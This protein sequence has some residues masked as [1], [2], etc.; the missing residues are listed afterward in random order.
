MRLWEKQE[1][2]TCHRIEERQESFSWPHDTRVPE[3]E[4]RPLTEL[5]L[6]SWEIDSREDITVSSLRKKE[7]SSHEIRKRRVTDRQD[8]PNTA[9]TTTKNHSR[10]LLLQEF[11]LFHSVLLVE[12]Y[13]SREWYVRGIRMCDQIHVFVLGQD[14][15]SFLILHLSLW[16]FLDTFQSVTSFPS[17]FNC[18]NKSQ[19]VDGQ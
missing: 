16:V 8:I 9:T 14:P 7:E 6:P 10:R 18:I 17:C 2:K 15:M 3:K 11:P 5:R 4:C 12:H 19:W 1:N 13:I